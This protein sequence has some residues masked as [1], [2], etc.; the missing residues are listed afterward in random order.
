MVKWEGGGRGTEAYILV[1]DVLEKFKLA[2]GA[3]R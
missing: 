2:V 3:L 1:L